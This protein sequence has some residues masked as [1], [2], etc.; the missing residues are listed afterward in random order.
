MHQ[1]LKNC[2]EKL[3]ILIEQLEETMAILKRGHSLFQSIEDEEAKHF[4]AKEMLPII[5]DFNEI[6]VN[7]KKSLEEYFEEER[8]ENQPIKFEYRSLYKKIKDGLNTKF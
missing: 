8:K 3:L 2:E 6:S 7:V 1:Q 4:F 5:D